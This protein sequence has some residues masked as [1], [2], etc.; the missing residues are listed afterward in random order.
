MPRDRRTRREHK[1]PRMPQQ[2]FV[3]CEIKTL[4]NR[5]RAH[6]VLRVACDQSCDHR[7][8]V[9]TRIVARTQPHDDE[10]A[11]R[12]RC[13]IRRAPPHGNPREKHFFSVISSCLKRGKKTACAPSHSGTRHEP[14]RS[15][16]GVA[17]GVLML[18]RECSSTCR[19][20]ASVNDL[21]ST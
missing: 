7:A 11:K 8:M 18:T 2:K 14:L 13:D 9:P 1:R 19:R 4:R 15:S 21:G 12:R 20:P 16:F 6:Y 3:G 10:Y 5:A 17:C